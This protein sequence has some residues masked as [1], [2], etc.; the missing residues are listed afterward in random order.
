MA[1]YYNPT[2]DDPRAATLNYK[3]QPR[4]KLISY[5]RNA[6]GTI[7][8]GHINRIFQHIDQ[9]FDTVEDKL[10]TIEVGAQ[11]HPTALEIYNILDGYGQC[12]P[13]AEALKGD[14]DSTIVESL[15]DI[16]RKCAT[17]Q[18]KNMMMGS[19]YIELDDIVQCRG[20]YHFDGRYIYAASGLNYYK[21]DPRVRNYA[22]DGTDTPTL[23]TPAVKPSSLYELRCI[24]S[25][26]DTLFLVYDQDVGGGVG[27]NTVWVVEVNIETGE[28]IDT[29]TIDTTAFDA[30]PGIAHFAVW[31]RVRERLWIV[32]YAS[33]IIEYDPAT[34]TETALQ[35]TNLFNPVA[36]AFDGITDLS[37]TLSEH[38]WILWE[39]NTAAP[40]EQLQA[41]ALDTFTQLDTFPIGADLGG[42]FVPLDMDFVNNFGLMIVGEVESGG[43]DTSYLIYFKLAASKVGSG[44]DDIW[45]FS[46]EELDGYGNHTETY[47]RPEMII[48]DGEHM[49]MHA[50]TQHL[51]DVGGPGLSQPAYYGI[52]IFLTNSIIQYNFHLQPS[53]VSYSQLNLKPFSNVTECS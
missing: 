4:E 32:C 25:N 1:N 8:T 12:V 3:I 7:S 17:P 42:T 35:G 43:L 31:N 33:T 53:R 47:P 21:I 52:P 40:T 9:R 10:A 30:A 14:Y 20:A 29:G 39:T 2:T 51:R 28:I 26:E 16:R 15:Y 48:Y 22:N 23:I 49:W 45:E 46:A 5:V 37:P 36:V 34:D 11:A 19:Q 13:C 18:L 24:T 6:D 38:L 27:S 41:I 44:Q 50:M